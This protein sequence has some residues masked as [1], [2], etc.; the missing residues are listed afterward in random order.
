M[1]YPVLM[2]SLV[3]RVQMCIQWAFGFVTPVSISNLL[4]LLDVDV[5]KE[6]IENLVF[7][8]QRNKTTHTHTDT[9]THTRARAHTYNCRGPGDCSVNKYLPY[10]RENLNS[11]FRIHDFFLKGRVLKCFP[12]PSVGKAGLGG[13]LDWPASVAQLTST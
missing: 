13:L 6:H 3:L 1:C 11:I 10:K 5:Y 4:I 9:H 12:N 8:F 7:G 2:V